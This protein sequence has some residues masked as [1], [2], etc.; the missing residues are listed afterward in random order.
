M[1]NTKDSANKQELSVF[2]LTLLLDYDT[3]I[4][5]PSVLWAIWHSAYG[6]RENLHFQ[7]LHV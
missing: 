7:I 5:R 3:S 6:V 2:M 4:C 1:R